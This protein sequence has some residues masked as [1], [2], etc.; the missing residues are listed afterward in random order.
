MIHLSS[1]VKII[2]YEWEEKTIPGDLAEDREFLR[3]LVNLFDKRG[4]RIFD[5]ALKH[6]G[7][8]AVKAR[9]YVG[10]FAVKDSKSRD[11]VLI[12]EPKIGVKN[13]I[14]MLA[15]NEARSFREVREIET[16]LSM[17]VGKESIMDLLIIGLVKG[18]MER[19]S[20]ALV[21]GFAETPSISV[22]E[23][24]VIRGRILSSTLS[25]T[26]LSNPVPKVA[27]EVQR[28]TTNNI[29]NHYILDACYM[30]YH[31][32]SDL[33][34]IADVDATVLRRTLFE[35]GYTPLAYSI[36]GV[37]PYELLNEVP[38]DRPYIHELLRLATIIKRW[39][40]Q[41]QPP[42]PEEFASVP[43]LYIN[44]NK[45]FE[46]FARKIMII[47]A[48][49]LRRSRNVN[50]TVRKAGKNE[51]ALVVSPKRRTYLEP[52]VVIEVN[53]NPVAVGDVK[54]KLIK[55]PLKSGSRGDREG[56]NQV[57]TFIH[58]W[59][60]EKGFLVYPSVK[61]E[62]SYER[63]ILKDGKKLYIVRIH[64]DERPKTSKEL[65]TSKMFKVLSDF[66]LELV[67]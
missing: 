10:I 60:V 53:G 33:L 59:D 8:I 54:Y 27:Y 66:L 18:F 9:N 65:R 25:K 41:G 57:Y 67:S 42:Y 13:I 17:P 19:L 37:S 40:E 22:E 3:R 29:L 23:D 63:Y 30:L 5:I 16:I 43:A 15:L 20:Q 11:V 45:L 28:Y 48:K 4:R 7:G 61:N 32:A 21:Y 36:G 14:W 55:D 39:L 56:V 35:L 52:D 24:A 47:I 64:A 62:T 51:R 12:V 2:M 31:G 6:D 44:M 38:L 34:K 26:L 46:G 50:I 49:W 58:G 1:T